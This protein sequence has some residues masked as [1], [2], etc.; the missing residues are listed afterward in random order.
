MVAGPPVDDE[1][2]ERIVDVDISDEVET[3]FIEDAYSVI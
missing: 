2:T 3:S 1:V